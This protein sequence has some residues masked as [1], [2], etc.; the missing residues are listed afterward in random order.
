[1]T[2][3]SLDFG[4]SEHKRTREAGEIME[5]WLVLIGA[6]VLGSALVAVVRARRARGHLPVLN[7][8][9]EDYFPVLHVELRGNRQLAEE[10][11]SAGYDDGRARLQYFDSAHSARTWFVNEE[12]KPGNDRQRQVHGALLREMALTEA[13]IVALRSRDANAWQRGVE[14]WQGFRAAVGI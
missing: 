13:M 10:L 2:L 12:L 14:A 9:N 11:V 6:L 5:A 1:M 3:T 8:G 4:G 7:Q